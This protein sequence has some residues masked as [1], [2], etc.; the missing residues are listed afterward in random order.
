MIDIVEAK[1]EHIP[2]MLEIW[3]ELMRHHADIDQ[4]SFGVVDD[5]VEIAA[6]FITDSIGNENY[7]LPVAIKDEVKSFINGLFEN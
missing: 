7:Y 5:A 6:G 1:P 3:V 4:E 2:G